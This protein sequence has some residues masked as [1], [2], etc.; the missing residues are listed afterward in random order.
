MTNC[1]HCGGVGVA[2]KVVPAYEA[3]GLRAPTK[4]VLEHAVK[5]EACAVCEASWGTSVPVW[6]VY[7]MR[8]FFREL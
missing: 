2:R 3:S 6:K 4:V 8:S 5:L 1:K 7:Y